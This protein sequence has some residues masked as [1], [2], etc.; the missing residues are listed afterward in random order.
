MRFA[1][2]MSTAGIMTIVAACAALSCEVPPPQQ[3]AREP[4]LRY[5]M[6][7]PPPTLDPV[8]ANDNNSLTYIYQIFDGL[9]E[10]APGTLD[11][12]PAVASSWTVSDDGTVYTF[13]LREGLTFHNGMPVTADDVVYSLRRGLKKSAQSQKR[14]FLAPLSGSGPFWDGETDKLP[15]AAAPDPHTVVLTLDQ[16]YAQFLTVLASEAGSIVPRRVYEDPEQAYLREPVGCGPFAI[17]SFEPDIAITLERFPQHWKKAPADGGLDGI[18]VRFI[19]DAST[20]LE[21]YRTGGLDFTYELPPGQRASIQSEMPEHFHHGQQLWILYLAFNHHA[22]PFKGNPALRRAIAHAIDAEFIV[23]NLQEGKD[24]VATGVIPPGMPGHAAAP[25]PW[26]YDV[27]KA[28]A[29]LAEAG[30]P[31][32]A[33]LPPLDYLTNETQGFRRILDRLTSD[34]AAIGVKLNA[35]EMDFGAFLGELTAQGGPRAPLWR[36][37]WFAD[38][39]DPD[40]FLGVQFGTGAAGNFGRYSNPAFDD[41][42]ARARRETDAAARADLF[43]QADRLLID[44]AALVPIYWYGTD[45]LLRPEFTGWKLSPMGAFAIA[46]EEVSVD[47]GG[48][49]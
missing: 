9:V 18:R 20:A 2:R 13:T 49:A 10:F 48:P 22:G 44:D 39:P 47:R 32:G 38:W 29:L 35:R 37:T 3:A 34:L 33:G 21:E 40:N 8:R 15:G 5:R 14:D 28:R 19:R 23:R 24:W 43:R 45:L 36:M 11:V 12:Q 26:P 25:A 27:E 41:L 6:D 7:Q 1:R 46:W 30:Y 4:V 16:P 42:V 31:E 17:A